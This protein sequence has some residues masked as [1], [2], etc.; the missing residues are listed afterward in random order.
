MNK[1]LFFSKRENIK[2]FLG[3]TKGHF[4][5]GREKVGMYSDQTDCNT[6]LKENKKQ[7]VLNRDRRS[8]SKQGPKGIFYQEVSLFILFVNP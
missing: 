6:I 4:P 1:R 2:K 3:Y 8:M 5:R 7:I